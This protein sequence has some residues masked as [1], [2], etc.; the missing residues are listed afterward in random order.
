MNLTLPYTT[1]CRSQ[2]EENIRY[3]YIPSINNYLSCTFL[4]IKQYFKTK[5][6]TIKILSNVPENVLLKTVE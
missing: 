5:S 2:S 3:S 6:A 1:I 4:I